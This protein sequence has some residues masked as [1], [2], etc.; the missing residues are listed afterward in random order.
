LLVVATAAC[1]SSRLEMKEL[2][3]RPARAASPILRAHADGRVEM[4]ADTVP[5]AAVGEDQPDRRWIEIARIG[6]DGRVTGRD[7]PGGWLARGGYVQED[8]I[9][10]RFRL[11]ADALI[12]N[13]P[14]MAPPGRVCKP[15][16]I[17]ID[18]TGEVRG[19]PSLSAPVH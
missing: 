13:G 10:T 4:F 19:V 6:A 1:S 17:T 14:E 8:S 15:R 9:G 16:R 12:A 18:D 7:R 2:S 5:Q 3:F 11:E